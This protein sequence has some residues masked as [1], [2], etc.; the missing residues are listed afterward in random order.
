L[1]VQQTNEFRLPAGTC[2]VEY[3]RQVR[4][5]RRPRDP[6]PIGRRFEAIPFRYL[7]REAQFRNSELKRL[8]ET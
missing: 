6:Q 8:S 3:V 4:A 1:F 7:E 5:R 2:L